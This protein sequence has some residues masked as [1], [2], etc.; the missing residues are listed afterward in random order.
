MPNR[1]GNV[2]QG[3]YFCNWMPVAKKKINET[4]D[5]S[6]IDYIQQQRKFVNSAVDIFSN[7]TGN[8][9]TYCEKKCPFSCLSSFLY[10]TYESNPWTSDQVLPSSLEY[11]KLKDCCSLISLTIAPSQEN[12]FY[13]PKYDFISTIS[14]VFGI[15]SLWLGIVLLDLIKFTRKFLEI[16]FKR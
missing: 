5:P 2:T 4:I 7:C 15:V 10:S 16:I 1:E 14:N 3:L 9:F 13:T 12:F 8:W 6:S 11:S